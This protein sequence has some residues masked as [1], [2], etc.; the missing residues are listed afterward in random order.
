[1]LS[2][3]NTPTQQDWFNLMH[4]YGYVKRTINYGLHINPN[5]ITNEIH[6]SADSAFAVHNNDLHKSHT[7]YII[8]YGS[9]PIHAKSKKQTMV[10]DSSS[11]AELIDMHTSINPGLFVTSIF[12]FIG[13]SKLLL[14]IH[15]DNTQSIRMA[16]D[17]TAN[18]HKYM[19]IKHSYMQDLIQRQ[20]IHIKYESGNDIVADILASRRHDAH[21]EQKREKLGIKPFN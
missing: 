12:N 21:F 19:H 17:T 5:N 3:I 4:L 10:C 14:V 16:Y 13:I 6:I 7:G 11:Y 9:S 20:L 2:C 8:Y 1:M 18:N 15:Q